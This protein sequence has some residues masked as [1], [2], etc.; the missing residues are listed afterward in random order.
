MITNED[1]TLLLEGVALL[2]KLLAFF[3]GY[4]SFSAWLRWASP[5]A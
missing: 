1:F 2:C 5:S 4:C 3:S